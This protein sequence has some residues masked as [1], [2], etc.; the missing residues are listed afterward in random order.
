MNT[1]RSLIRHMRPIDLLLPV[2]AALVSAG[3]HN[4]AEREER[5]RGRLERLAQLVDAHADAL[6]ASGIE[7]PADLAGDESH[8]LDPGS[9]VMGLVAPFAGGRDKP[10]AEPPR[11]R[12]RGL[13]ALGVLAAAGVAGV[14]LAPRILARLVDAGVLPGDVYAEPADQGQGDLDPA[15]APNGSTF[16]EDSSGEH[17]DLPDSYRTPTAL[18]EPHPHSGVRVDVAQLDAGDALPADELADVDAAAAAE[19]T[20]PVASCGW[21]NCDWQSDAGRSETAQLTQA[22]VHR[23]RCSWRPAN[24]VV[25]G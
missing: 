2:G 11:P 8:P 23:N 1:L 7:L 12:R 22:A 10:P 20:P 4:L 16:N 25:P 17:T 14:T 3:L 24:A 15:A 6:I 21:P 19:T 5:Q 9:P 13:V 18:P